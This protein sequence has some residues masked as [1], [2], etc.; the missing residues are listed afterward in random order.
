M[1]SDINYIFELLTAGGVSPFIELASFPA[2]FDLNKMPILHADIFG[3]RRVN[4]ILLHTSIERIS[5][6]RRR[7][8]PQAAC[9]Q[10]NCMRASST[11]FTHVEYFE[12]ADTRRQ[13]SQVLS[14]SNFAEIH[15]RPFDISVDGCPQSQISHQDDG[16]L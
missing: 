15:D 2:F 13:Q 4:A 1:T 11:R 10:Q 12:T 16:V 7:G 8:G 5:R 14:R 9:C 6:A 3:S